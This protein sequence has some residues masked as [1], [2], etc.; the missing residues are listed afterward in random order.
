LRL[1][2]FTVNDRSELLR[3][4]Q[5]GVDGVFTDYPERAAAFR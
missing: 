4:R 2:V 3:L 5:L 1:L